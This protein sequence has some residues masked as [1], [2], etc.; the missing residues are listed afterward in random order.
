MLKFMTINRY[1]GE[2]LEWDEA[3][4]GARSTG[5]AFPFLLNK[6]MNQREADDF[7]A[8]QTEGKTSGLSS[9]GQFLYRIHTVKGE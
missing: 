7:Q 9:T 2:W 1:S 6:P 4:K 3:R 5:A 8:M